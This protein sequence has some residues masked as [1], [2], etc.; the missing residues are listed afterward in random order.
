MS[1]RM[2]WGLKLLCERSMGISVWLKHLY[3]PRVCTKTIPCDVDCIFENAFGEVLKRPIFINI[4]E[5]R[6]DQKQAKGRWDL[7]LPRMRREQCRRRHLESHLVGGELLTAAVKDTSLHR[8][9]QEPCG[10]TACPGRTVISAG[11][12]PV[13]GDLVKHVDNGQQQFCVLDHTL[14]LGRKMCTFTWLLR[15][16][17]VEFYTQINTFDQIHPHSL[18]LRKLHFVVDGNW[19][20]L[21]TGQS[22][23]IF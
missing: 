16:L 9:W 14:N 2:W 22:V 20:R 8:Q 13:S 4:L 17:V 3:G 5:N 21:I 18:H 11:C 15:I 6:P 1:C 23:E 10:C 19:H 7:I 12:S